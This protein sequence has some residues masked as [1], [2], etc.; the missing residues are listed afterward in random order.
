MKSALKSILPAPAVAGLKRGFGR[1]GCLLQSIPPDARIFSSPGK[2]VFFGYYDVSPFQGDKVLALR[3]PAENISPHVN[4][5]AAEIGFFD[6]TQE[7]PQFQAFGSTKTWNWQQGCR[8]QWLGGTDRVIY[9]TIKEGAFAAVVQDPVLGRIE[10]TYAAPIYA[11]SGDG[12]FALGLDFG[13]LHDCRPGYGYSNFPDAPRKDEIYKVTLESGEIETIVTM[14]E[15]KN[16]MPLESMN[17][18]DHYFN[19]LSISPGGTCFMVT[20]LWV[21]AQG[22]RYTRILI[23]GPDGRDLICPN[24]TGKTSHYCWVGDDAVVI[25]AESAGGK[26]HYILYDLKGTEHRVLGEKT[27]RKDGHPT[28]TGDGHMIT[29]TYPDIMRL[30][31]LMI[32]DQH[33]ESVKTLAKFYV[34]EDFTGEVRCDLHPRVDEAARRICVDMVRNNARALCVMK[35]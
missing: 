29:D 11:V 13:R 19:H 28:W 33:H 17:G 12:R 9:N 18:A 35:Y 24:N 1:A 21:S 30:Q 27:L 2:Q 4:L 25:F 23:A 5:P 6:L 15:V 14:D 26:M 3:V 10:K 7:A 20:H 16:F 34:P 22:Q 32:Y 8:L 31:H